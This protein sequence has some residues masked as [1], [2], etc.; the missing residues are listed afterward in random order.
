MPDH[1]ANYKRQDSSAELLQQEL[2][3]F[4]LPTS[5]EKSSLLKILGISPGFKQT[6]DAVRLHVASFQNI[7]TAKDFDLLEIKATDKF[8][9]ALPNGF[10]FGLTEN[11]EML[12][13][14]FE[15]KYFLCLVS[16]NP[17][18]R[19]YKLVSWTE[20]KTLIQHKRVQYQI[21]LTNTVVKK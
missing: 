21:N 20:L 7:S 19:N 8:L 5:A 1:G 18:S 13:K 9:P 2:P 16:L 10:F 17:K 4:Y 15:G 11:E 3:G 6:F 12:L 14:V